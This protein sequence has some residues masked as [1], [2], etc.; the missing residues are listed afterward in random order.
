MLYNVPLY[1]EVV[2]VT[3]ESQDV[4]DQSLN[5]DHRGRV[6]DC[7]DNSECACLYVNVGVY[8]IFYK[9]GKCMWMHAF[10]FILYFK[11]YI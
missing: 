11:N 1:S 8:I 2:M 3:R 4:P 6:C 9:K 5:G 10:V 7:I